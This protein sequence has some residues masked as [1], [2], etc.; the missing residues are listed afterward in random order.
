MDS[1]TDI[2]RVLLFWAMNASVFAAAAALAGRLGIRDRT[3]FW[4]AVLVIYFTIINISLVLLGLF[5]L[6]WL[7]I[8]GPLSIIPG[9][10]VLFRKLADKNRI[11]NP[12]PSENADYFTGK[13]FF[14]IIFFSVLVL[15]FQRIDNP[16]FDHDPLTYQLYFPGQWLA[17]HR[18]D[19]IPT[20]FGDNSRAYEPSNASLYYLWLML[21]LR[22]DMF[23]QLGQL[24]FFI[25][26]LL[27]LTGISIRLGV[28]RPW[29]HLPAL[30]FL[31][32]PIAYK[33]AGSAGNDLAVTAAFLA[34]IYFTVGSGK[35]SDSSEN[36]LAALSIGLLVGT[37]YIG[38]TLLA[39]LF[40]LI[41]HR[42]IQIKRREGL[43]L[44]RIFF[45]T[46]LIFMAGGFW[47]LRNLFVA[48]N[49]LYPL[50]V[51]FLGKVILAGAYPPETMR[52]WVFHLEGAS[53]QKEL[54]LS[55]L[56]PVVLAAFIVSAV[57][58]LTIFIIRRKADISRPVFLYLL[59]LPFLVH[60][61]NWH[62]VPFQ[63][64]RFWLPAL[65]AAFIV[66]AMMT[67]LLPAAGFACI[68]ILLVD[69]LLRDEFHTFRFWHWPHGPAIFLG[70][71]YS[72]WRLKRGPLIGTG[73][74]LLA[75]GFSFYA[76][77]E[78]NNDRADNLREQWEFG[79]GWNYLLGKK[80]P[81]NIAYSG[82]NVPYPLLGHRLSNKASYV[83]INSHPDW[84]FHDYERW[85]RNSNNS[86]TPNTPEPALYR[87]EWNVEAWWT[88]LVEAKV[89]YLF[90]TRVGKNTLVNVAHDKQGWPVESWWA[91]SHPEVFRMVY[92]D[93]FVRIF[94]ID[95]NALPGL[96]RAEKQTITRPVD[97]LAVYK[98]D[99][100]ALEKFFPLARAVI[101]EF[102]LNP[103]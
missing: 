35:D 10:F 41:L 3:G 33:Q 91:L 92:E 71:V 6:I 43:S 86:V 101:R 16:V 48:G 58:V 4:I 5:G 72:A 9:A 99:P 44:A 13:A 26:A 81:L 88:N 64:E 85:L 62:L 38:L 22:S 45:W 98:K 56:S 65:A 76:A 93:R 53:A 78:Y 57:A 66:F 29:H 50:R 73:L 36:M 60:L 68:A 23:A 102:R 70:L 87:L 21:G 12:G 17:H 34:V 67:R 61:L 7:S 95:R 94:S 59:A 25:L 2:L 19:I 1:F 90:I 96:S 46:A 14:W 79:G 27:S 11:F 31:F 89:D 47:Y 83:N 74:V 20:P 37:K 69:L 15:F 84:K 28:K 80:E 100:G 55:M 18:L 32:T 103:P 40:P 82:S 8:I 42:L 39:L 54:L 97:A 24:P 49:P 51:S 77:R 63:M 75:A 52:N 30:F